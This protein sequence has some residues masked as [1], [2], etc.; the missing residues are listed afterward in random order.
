LGLYPR[1]PHDKF[2]GWTVCSDTKKSCESIQCGSQIPEGRL[3]LSSGLFSL[4]PL[5]K[6]VE[7]LAAS[8][9]RIAGF[10][11]LGLTAECSAIE[12][13]RTIERARF[14]HDW[15]EPFL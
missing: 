6:D 7:G 4:R 10:S 3:D 8:M 15:R 1:K 14:G 9:I 13:L 12:L 2:Q 5:G 11:A